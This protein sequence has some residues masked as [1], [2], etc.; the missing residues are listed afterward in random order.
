M[1]HPP[2]VLQG[3]VAAHVPAVQIRGIDAHP[4]VSRWIIIAMMGTE[5]KGVDRGP[6]QAKRDGS[7][8]DVAHGGRVS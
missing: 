8:Y 5:K 3:E 6:V 1:V 7:Q 4:G 2:A